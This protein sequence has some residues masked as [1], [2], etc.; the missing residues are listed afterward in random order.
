[1]PDLEDESRPASFP[2]S[3]SDYHRERREVLAR[4]RKYAVCCYLIF[5][6][7]LAVFHGFRPLIGL[8]WSALVAIVSFLWLEGIV[9]NILQPAPQMQ[10]WKLVLRT[11]LR[12]AF[13]GL[14]LTVALSAGFQPLSLLLGFS[15]VVGAIM[16]EA[17][18]SITKSE[19]SAG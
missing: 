9:G 13:L 18:R 1:M 12:F 3:E 11:F 6:I 19:K 8:T 17:V 2:A 15:V 16:I 10:S 5:A 14:A 7:Y 4:L